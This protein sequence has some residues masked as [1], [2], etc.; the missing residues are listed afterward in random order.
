[1]FKKF[2]RLFTGLFAS[3]LM[4]TTVSGCANSFLKQKNVVISDVETKN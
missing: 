4:V 2:K 1:M 3:L